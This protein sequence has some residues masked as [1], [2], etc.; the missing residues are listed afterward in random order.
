MEGRKGRGEGD[1]EDGATGAGT[2]CMLKLS[3]ERIM[4]CPVSQLGKPT[5]YPNRTAEPRTNGD[6]LG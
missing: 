5:G 2:C 4:Q 3:Y 6:R 1:R